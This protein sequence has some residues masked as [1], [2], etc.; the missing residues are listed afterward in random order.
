M[1]IFKV[2]CFYTS[3][4]LERFVVSRNIRRRDIGTD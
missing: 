2:Y 4:N 3:G 1:Q